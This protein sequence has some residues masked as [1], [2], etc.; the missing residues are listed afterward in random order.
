MGRQDT[1]GNEKKQQGGE[2]I[3][4]QNC[5][6]FHATVCNALFCLQPWVFPAHILQANLKQKS[7]VTHN[8][9]AQPPS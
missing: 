4:R 9:P 5:F 7:K 1:E 8:A 3:P 6:L 2:G